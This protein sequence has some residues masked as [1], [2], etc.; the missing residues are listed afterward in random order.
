[1]D[2]KIVGRE[3]ELAQL[4]RYYKSKQSEFVAVYGRRRV[5]KT[6][7]VRNAFPRIDFQYTAMMNA[8][9]REQ[10]VCFANA[11]REQGLVDA[12]DVSSWQE[13]FAEL[14]RFICT[15]PKSRK[16]VIF[17]DELP[18]MDKSDAVFIS[19]FEHFWNSWASARNDIMLVVCGSATSW[20]MDKLINNRGGLHNRITLHI[21]FEPF[22]LKETELYLKSRKFRW[23]RMMIAECYMIFGGIPYYLSLLDPSLSLARNVDCL[24]FR[25][26]AVLRGEFSNLYASLFT[27][28]KLYIGIVQLLGS[29]KKGLSRDEIVK[30]LKLADGGTFSKALADLENC[31]FI[32]NYTPFDKKKKTALFQLVDFYTLFYLNFIWERKI[33]DEDFWSK[34][35]R[36]TLRNA[37]IDYAFEQLCLAHVRQIKQGLGISGV[38]TNVYSWRS[39]QKER[40]AQIDLV[41]DRNDNSIT[42]CEMKWTNRQYSITA[43]YEKN[44]N[45]KV[46][47]FVEENETKKS[48]FLTMI[49]TQG[50]LSNSHSQILDNNLILNDLFV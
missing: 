20:M 43:A 5:G 40:G 26:N 3:Q 44:L 36:S 41:I 18:W 6:F 39:T 46:E 19:A 38:I 22:S 17:L 30:G 7:L 11:L 13:A 23:G 34:N 9:R 8:S 10:L 48:V 47:T 29:K 45:N 32:R 31:G 33:N 21:R 28:S 42:L 14:K 12:A 24:F 27:N 50:V 1:M 4:S 35:S 2:K 37:W 15:L 49:T 16:K 25:Q